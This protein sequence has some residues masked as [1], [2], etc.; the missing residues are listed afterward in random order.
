MRDALC[1]VDVDG[2]S[3]QEARAWAEQAGDEVR[4]VVG[5]TGSATGETKLT[6]PMTCGT[7]LPDSI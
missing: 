4:H 7:A 6:R 3:G 2:L 5:D 1:T